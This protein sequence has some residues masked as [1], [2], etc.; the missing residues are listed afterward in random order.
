M[1]RRAFLY[2][3]LLFAGCATPREVKQA[4]AALDK[5]Y[6]ANVA[7]MQQY[8]DTLDS[9]NQ[10][11][12]SWSR[13]IKTRHL[14][15]LAIQCTTLD[16]SANAATLS[17][18]AGVLGSDVVAWINV[19]RL[20]GLQRQD[21]FAQGTSNVN[22]LVQGLPVLASL[23]R[24]K[25]DAAIAAQEKVRDLTPFDQYAKNVTL[26]KNANGAVQEYLDIDVTVSKDDV[27]SI[28][29]AIEQLRSGK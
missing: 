23:I 4:T 26:L 14:L 9:I 24:K 16:Q 5:G 20:S 15:N 2:A 21:P 18:R 3:L 1:F 11:H 22:D 10:L 29:K 17:A 27:E 12:H 19:H 25:V 28:V 8:R 6:E 7:L 13:Y